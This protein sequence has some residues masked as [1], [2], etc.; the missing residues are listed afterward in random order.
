MEK[1]SRIEELINDISAIS[2]LFKAVWDRR[3]IYIK[4]SIIAAVLSLVVSFSVPKIYSAKVML[5]PENQNAASGLASLVGI[6]IAQGNTDAY[7]VDLYPMIISSNDF[8]L[9][10]FDIELAVSDIPEGVTYF[11]YINKHQKIAWWNYPKKWLGELRESL[12]EKKE[13]QEKSEKLRKLTGKEAA[14]CGKIKKNIRCT[15]N[16]ASGIITVMVHDQNPEVAVLMADSVVNRLNAFILDYRT[17]KARS[18]YEYV[19]EMC[20]AARQKYVDWQEVVADFH[21]SHVSI[22]SPLHKKEQ[23]FIENELTLS[24]SAYRS[25]VSQVEVARAKLL[26]ATPVYTIIESAYVPLVADSPRKLVMLVLFVFFACI[27][28]TIKV[29]YQEYNRRK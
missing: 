15:V 29:A 23:Q 7:T 27:L 20:I 19:N 11:D 14:A 28:A 5:A 10:L 21:L 6:D 3:R 18:D 16:G 24:Y 25:L 17:R 9:D 8:I 2:K 12:G 22:H 26:E 1:K 4:Y 13:E